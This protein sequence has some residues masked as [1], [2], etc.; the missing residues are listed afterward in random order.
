MTFLEFMISFLALCGLVAI[1][2]FVC[3]FFRKLIANH[4][5]EAAEPEVPPPANPGLSESWFYELKMKEL[6]SRTNRDPLT[7]LYNKGYFM[8]RLAESLS[9]MKLHHSHLGLVFVDIDNFKQLNDTYGHPFGD[10][11]LVE[12]A[13]TMEKIGATYKQFDTCRY[14][15][16]E[17][18]LITRGL[19]APDT[20]ELAHHLCR[21]V[22]ELKFADQPHIRVTLSIGVYTVEF[23]PDGAHDH[24]EMMDFIELADKQ[25]YLAKRSGK[26]RVCAQKQP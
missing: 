1:L 23:R 19:P 14:G 21:E 10:T 13:R 3:Q 22:S 6:A 2:W 5:L 9:E 24:L 20:E 15:G 17:L 25:L 8:D 4:A 18:T 7:N 16:E 12:V 26:N 11:V